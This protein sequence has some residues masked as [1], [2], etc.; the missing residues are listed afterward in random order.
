MQEKNGD[1]AC[2]LGEEKKELHIF[3]FLESH[4]FYN[5]Y[6]MD[7]TCNHMNWMLKSI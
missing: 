7:K 6:T 3:T 2:F 1:D 4:E 5:R